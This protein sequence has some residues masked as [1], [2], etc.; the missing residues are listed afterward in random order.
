M[1][2][3]IIWCG[4]RVWRGP[5]PPEDPDIKLWVEEED[6]EIKEKSKEKNIMIKIKDKIDNCILNIITRYR[7]EKQLRKLRKQGINV[8]LESMKIYPEGAKVEP[9]L[10]IEEE[11]K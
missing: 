5:Y 4:K 6:E 9:S 1:G 7:V 3:E 11:E 10:R 8:K 2:K